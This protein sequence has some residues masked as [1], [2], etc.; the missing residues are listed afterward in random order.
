MKTNR[1][2]LREFRRIWARLEED[3][4]CDS[5]D[6]MQ[7]RRVSRE[8]FCGA[9]LRDDDVEGFIKW[10]ANMGPDPDPSDGEDWVKEAEARRDRFLFAPAHVRTWRRKGWRWPL[11]TD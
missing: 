6:G 11:P 10:R 1:E 5:I 9:C 8:W 3:G 2:A 7:Y 4:H